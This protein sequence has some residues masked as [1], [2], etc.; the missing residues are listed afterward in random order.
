MARFTLSMKIVYAFKSEVRTEASVPSR[1]ICSASLLNILISI[2]MLHPQM[3]EMIFPAKQTLTNLNTATTGLSPSSVNS[4][5]FYPCR[6]NNLLCPVTT[7][8]SICLCN[9]YSLVLRELVNR[10]RL[11]RS[12]PIM[13][14]IAQHFIPIQTMRLSLAHIS[15]LQLWPM[16]E[17]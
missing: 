14:I 12:V 4:T 10:L 7:K 13:R 11:T 3:P 15:Q 9:R 6:G 5:K 17:I 8:L 2:L 1:R 16:S